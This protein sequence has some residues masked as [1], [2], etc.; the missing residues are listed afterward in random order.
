M[1][2]ILVMKVTR[3]VS[4]RVVIV[5]VI[6][7]GLVVVGMVTFCGLLMRIVV[8]VVVKR[9]EYDNGD[10]TGDESYRYSQ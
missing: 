9:G 1:L 6:V 4:K 3:I 2:M 5:A 10:E 8:V 7:V